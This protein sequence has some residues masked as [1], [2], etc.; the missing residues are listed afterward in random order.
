MPRTKRLFLFIVVL[1]AL[2][3]KPML[4]QRPKVGLVLSGGGA[5]GLAH[6]GVLK[7]IDSA[8]LKIDYIAGTS[9]GAIIGGLYSAG[10]SGNQIE[11]IANDI[12]WQQL[13]SGKP[14]Y[15][16]VG[17]DEKDEFENY[18]AMLP[19][20]HLKPVLPT[21]VVQAQEIWYKFGELFFP[22]YRT[23]DFSKLDIP[24]MCV[25]TD[26]KTGQPV[27]LKNGD[28]ISSIR[29]SMAIPGVFSAVD[30]N[31]KRLFDGGV[32]RNF[33]VQEVIDMGA[34]IVIGVN[35]TPELEK[36]TEL[37]TPLN[38]LS[39]LFVYVISAN[40]DNDKRLCNIL[41]E[42]P[43]GDYSP[44]NFDKDAA[45]VA[46]GNE[47]GDK[48]YHQFRVL[49][50]SLAQI[51]PIVPKNG[52]RLPQIENVVIDGI[53]VNGLE[54]THNALL[55][56][57]LGIVPGKSYTP[58]EIND[59]FRHAYSLLYYR[60]LNYHL[61][62][63]QPGHALL[64]VELKEVELNQLMFGLSYHT[65]SD[66]ALIAGYSMRDM[67]G[68]QSRTLAKVAFGH[69]W[70]IKL[71]HKQAFGEKLNNVW[72][73]QGTADKMFIP[74]YVDTDLRNTYNTLKYT[75]HVGYSRLLSNSLAFGARIGTGSTYF[76]PEITMGT[77]MSGY[78]GSNFASLFFK[79]NSLNN[80][81]LPTK[82][83][84]LSLDATMDVNRYYRYVDAVVSPSDRILERHSTPKWRFFVRLRVLYAHY[85]ALCVV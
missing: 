51:E 25:A 34:D 1:A 49:A 11:T 69:N 67:L 72:E 77:N 3:G 85:L 66:A 48:F 55:M 41:I 65:F 82:G 10:Y 19:M 6:I 23:N 47:T 84:L 26:L 42:P 13:F 73:I 45:I 54:K 52:S 15:R 29:A 60:Y 17:M 76:N 56:Q 61:L 43:L 37:N 71:H 4:A 36:A 9:M 80:R 78:S 53:T 74:E 62:P 46:V 14:S 64:Q 38:V 63:M 5:K 27:Y 31:G 50:D 2:L 83:R 44:A 68:G 21:G 39:Q 81:Y 32:T 28:L 24:F 33:P 12:D 20:R 7:A 22:V 59:A 18:S 8:G 16:S 35:L 30:Y 40:I 75:A 70:R 58:D 79:H 57:G